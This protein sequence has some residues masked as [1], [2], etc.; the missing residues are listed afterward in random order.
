M[1]QLPVETMLSWLSRPM[2]V[3]LYI[4]MDTRGCEAIDLEH[5]LLQLARDPRSDVCVVASACDLDIGR[6]SREVQEAAD[7]ANT[8]FRGTPVLSPRLRMAMQIGLEHGVLARRQSQMRSAHLL[9]AILEEDDLRSWLWAVSPTLHALEAH[10]LH[11]KLE[12]GLESSESAPIG[13]TGSASGTLPGGSTEEGSAL[14]KYCIDLTQQARSGKID[15]VLGRHLEIEQV[16]NVLGRRRANNPILVGEAGVGKTA[17]VEGLAL[18]IVSGDVPEPLKAASIRSLDLGLLK[19]GAGVR[20]EIEARLKAIIDETRSSPSPVLLFVDEA[21]T[22]MGSQS[23]QD[24]VANLLKPA[25]ARGELRM[26]A[27]TTWGEYKEFIEKDPAMKRR[28]QEIPVGEPSLEATVTILR[29]LAP[30]FE[31]AHGVRILDEALVEAVRVSTRYLPSRQQPEKAISVLDTACAKIATG[32]QMRPA[33]IDVHAQR[34]RSLQQEIEC[35]RKEAAVDAARQDALP[36]LE[37]RLVAEEGELDQL[38]K[39]WELQASVSARLIGLRLQ[40]ENPASDSSREEAVKEFACMR[41]ELRSQGED[42]MLVRPWVDAA[43]VAD[44]V[45]SW[46]GIPVGR[47]TTGDVQAVRTLHEKLEARVIGQ[48]HA[49]EKITSKIKAARTGL[50]NPKRPI[51]VFLLVGTSGVGKTET[52]LALAEA[53]YGDERSMIFI[54]LGEFKEEH[55]VSQLLGPPPGY[56]GFEQGG[57][58]TEAVRRRPYSLVLLDELEK[59]HPGV[60][61]IFYRVFSDGVLQDGQGRM[62]DFR[63]T[64][65]VLTSNVGTEYL[66][67][68]FQSGE[69]GAMNTA[70]IEK[71][72]RS[73]LER[74]FRPEFLGRVEIVPYFPLGPSEIGQI[75]R[76]QLDRLRQR[77]IESHGTGLECDEAVI[78]TITERCVTV[79]SGARDVDQVINRLLMSKLADRLLERMAE[80]KPTSRI[81]VALGELGEPEP[82]LE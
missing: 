76:L 9:L 77:L 78:R 14:T 70:T 35:C 37:A 65:I 18:R 49:L 81:R 60:Q 17:V 44:V 59:A 4:A 8:G 3:A 11:E 41:E 28:F 46:T 26:I 48:S 13:H 39:R 74:V 21:H 73:Q 72:I 64:I 82:Q 34:V 29:G 6:V 52:A 61:D 58:L 16:V 22:L 30:T 33:I 38:K 55:K 68:A 62:V 19:A 25:L 53:L 27:A 66:L 63:N 20:G 67:H 43:C 42:L 51:G 12:S 57:V 1:N 23:G 79:R 71:G 7:R 69:E 36:G 31:G 75:V 15:P 56:K 47:M 45:S 50:Q 10:R 2:K 80:G 5:W 54:N 40:L 24:D 32:L